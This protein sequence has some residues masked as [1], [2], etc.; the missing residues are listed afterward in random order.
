MG[1]PAF[2]V[3]TL[4]RLLDEGKNVVGV[5]TSIDKY[6]GRGKKKL[7]ESDVKKFAE[8]KSLPILQP[9]NLKSPEFHK[10]LSALKADLQI[11]VAFRMLPEIVWNMPPL[12]TYN[13][14][15][16]LLPKYRGAAPIH[17]AVING[18][19]ETGVTTFK[20]KHQIDTGD[21]ILQKKIPIDINDT[22]GDVHDRLMVVGAE[23]MLETVNR[24]E[25]G[26]IE[27]TEQDESQVCK[28]PKLFPEMCKI[29][30]TRSNA[31][32]HNFIRGLNP[33]PGAWTILKGQKLKIRRSTLDMTN[34]DL[35]P[36]KFVS[37]NVDFI[38]VACSEGFIRIHELQLEGKKSMEVSAF[39]NG[40]NF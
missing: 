6:G 24:V 12:G 36:G 33:F 34:H 14:H 22:T 10:E 32:V 35:R 31:T 23:A 20:L 7:I 8:S 5:V 2:A 25:S 16:S 17:W 3:A 9:K 19:K 28:A 30:F 26:T 15:G 13:L 38:K 11:V 18:E 21:M 39:L 1:T 4:K 37:N 27:F 29:D 40:Y